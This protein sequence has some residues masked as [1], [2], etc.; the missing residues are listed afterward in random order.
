MDVS[1]SFKPLVLGLGLVV[2]LTGCVIYDP[3]YSGPDHHSYAPH[4]YP[5]YHDYYYYPSVQVYFSF[6]TGHYFYPHGQRWVRTKILPSHIFLDSRERVTTRV[7][8]DKPYLK[9]R[10]HIQAYQPSRD[11]RPDPQKHRI[12]QNYNLKSYENHQKKQ[13]IYEQE[14]NK[15]R[16][17]DKRLYQ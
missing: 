17:K 3:Y 8:G 16:K 5:F 12:A 6:S 14:W 15:R 7:K 4:F 13:I 11:Y 9:N 10:Q 2:G 1:K